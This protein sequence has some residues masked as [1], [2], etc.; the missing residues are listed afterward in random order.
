MEV[1]FYGLFMDRAILLQNGIKPSNPRKGYLNDYAL[2]IGNRASLVP[3]NNEKS[4]GIVMTV[5]NDAIHKLYAEASVADY[6]PQEVDII[7]NRRDPVRAICYNLPVGLIT[8]TNK[9]YAVS[10]YKLAKR[11]GFP[12]DYLDKIK[13]MTK[14]DA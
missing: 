2:K 9:I 7:V 13:K 4:Y 6:I 11:K 12:H 14:K 8:G 5:D 10:L 1:F 3:C